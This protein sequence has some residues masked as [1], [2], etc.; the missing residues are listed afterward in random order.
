MTLRGKPVGERAPEAARP[1]SLG[2]ER[3]IKWHG[4]QSRPE[5]CT[6][7][8][9]GRRDR[10]GLSRRRVWLSACCDEATLCLL[11]PLQHLCPSDQLVAA[12]TVAASYT[13]AWFTPDLHLI[14]T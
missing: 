1:G 8:V 14:Y 10:T 3:R 13:G 2:S 9:A 7:K 11:S 12:G 4:G 6:R 5:T